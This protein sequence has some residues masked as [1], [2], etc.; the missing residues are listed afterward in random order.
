MSPRAAACCTHHQK[1]AGAE[2][3][4]TRGKL[5]QLW[6]LRAMRIEFHDARP[7]HHI[8]LILQSVFF[9]TTAMLSDVK[10]LWCHERA[11][12]EFE[13]ANFLLLHAWPNI[14]GADFQTYF[15]ITQAWVLKVLFH[16]SDFV[17]TFRLLG[18]SQVLIIPSCSLSH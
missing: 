7:A 10:L 6:V 16:S 8:N 15:C 9:C 1:N 14:S 18:V 4:R 5:G 12:C 3:E 17:C 11:P 2:R 13:N